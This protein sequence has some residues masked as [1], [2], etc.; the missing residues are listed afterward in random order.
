M[1]RSCNTNWLRAFATL[2]AALVAAAPAHAVVVLK[3]GV[4]QPV[5]GHLVRQDER[6]VVVREELPG[7]GTRETH[8]ARE[9][10]D[11]LILTVDPA[12]L[13]ALDPAQ[14][15][16]YREYAEELAEKRRDP[17]AAGAA[18][19]LYAIAAARS[20]GGLRQG[21]L[22]GLIALARSP[23]EER[24]LRA[25]AFLH[26]E[27]H[28]AT[29]LAKTASSS[30]PANSTPDAPPAE[31]LSAIRLL[32]QGR[33]ADAKGLL[34]LP[35]VGRGAAAV[36]DSIS[37]DEMLSAAAAKTL[38]DTQLRQ[39]LGAEL[40]LTA[41]ASAG[42][43]TGRQTAWS[44][45]IKAGQIAPVPALRIESLTEFDPAECVFRNGK[46]TRP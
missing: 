28:D 15:Q 16:A 8:V 19:R 34:D 45:T 3:K 17:E 30:A 9:S 6:E 10:I 5:I 4:P 1:P 11:E 29:V 36:A 23:D 21:A 39:L 24:R 14:P 44:E 2:V 43:A 12:R 13:A 26:D 40:S 46:W 25:A 32:R 7:G 18:R 35:Q 37:V 41:G 42:R 33:G 20:N 31:L 22:L 38:T 27:R